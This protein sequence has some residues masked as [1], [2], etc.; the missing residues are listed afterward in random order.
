MKTL[1]SC[2]Y[3]MDNCC[4]ELKFA[5]SSMIAI[6]TIAVENEVADNMYQRSELDYL[7][8]NDPIGYADL[9]LNGDPETYLKTVTEYKPLDS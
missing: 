4:V 5:D 7:I 3:N 6:D 9:I 1:I 2:A 8:Y